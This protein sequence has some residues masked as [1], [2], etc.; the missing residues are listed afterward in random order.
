MQN[1]TVVDIQ[2]GDSV[3]LSVL[4]PPR[5][6]TA[7]ILVGEFGREDWPIREVNESWRTW[8]NR[9]GFERSDNPSILRVDGDNNSLDTVQSSNKSTEPAIAVKIPINRPM[10]AAYSDAQGGRHSTGLVLSLIH[11]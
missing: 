11:I 8:Y 9:G 10:A 4:A 2:A 5:T 7:I 1:S 3:L 6:D